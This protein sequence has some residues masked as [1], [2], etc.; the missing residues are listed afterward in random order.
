MSVKVTKD[1]TRMKAYRAR[2]GSL[3][4]NPNVKVGV[5]G[6]E[7]AA[8]HGGT[9]TAQVAAVHELGAGVPR[10]SWLR[11]WVEPH[12]RQIAMKM[13]Q[14]VDAIHR[15]ARPDRV[16]GLIGV[17]A[18]GQIQRRISDNIGPA[19][20]PATIARKGS[21]VTLIDTGQLRASISH[22]LEK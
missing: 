11:D 3:N 14:A 12:R 21:S 22:A 16:L 9:T 6:S 8:R 2:L 5:L 17:W 1:D 13:R 18:V 7:A 4:R 20:S 10:R 15:G 19:L